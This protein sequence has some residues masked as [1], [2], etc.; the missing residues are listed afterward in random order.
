MPKSRP[1]ADDEWLLLGE[2]LRAVRKA[3]GLTLKKLADDAGYGERTVRRYESGN[4]PVELDVVDTLAQTLDV[5]RE[6]IAR[7]P[8][9]VR[10]PRLPS[11][12]RLRQLVSWELA[13]P[14]RP[15]VKVD[16]KSIVRL[17][18]KA[19]HD[20]N[21]AWRVHEDVVFAVVGEVRDQ[22][23]LDAPEAK[24]L[25]CARGVGASFHVFVPIVEGEALGVTVHA[26]DA[27]STRRMQA[28][29]G[30]NATLAARVIVAPDDLPA[31]AGF[32]FFIADDRAERHA[33][34]LVLESIEE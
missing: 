34:T 28:L 33:W 4:T 31:G 6:T 15:P 3:N 19:L 7:A 11:P 16:G 20:V 27:R 23:D 1:P 26:R 29:L 21:T 24:L 25:G 30:K 22:R 18:A 13:A 32:S 12:T 9:A 10:D 8:V 14:A 17:G 5:S 2:K